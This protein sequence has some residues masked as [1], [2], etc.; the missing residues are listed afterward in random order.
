M[1]VRRALPYSTVNLVVYR[2]AEGSGQATDD[3]K[4]ES[5]DKAKEET[6]LEKIPISVK[7]GKQ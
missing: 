7:V 1:R 5:S 3:V 6:K 2:G 4:E